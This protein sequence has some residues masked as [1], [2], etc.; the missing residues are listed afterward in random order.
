MK[1]EGCGGNLKEGAKFCN[2]CGREVSLRHRA[3]GETAHLAKETEVVA[4][5]LGHG[6]VGGAKG[7]VSGAK[8]GFTGSE[9]EKKE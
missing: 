9:E 7:L 8:K 2:A 5:K 6:I 3:E 4:R 1:C